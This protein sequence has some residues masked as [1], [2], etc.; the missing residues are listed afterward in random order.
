MSH[1]KNAEAF[2][3]LIGQCTGYAGGYQPGSSNLQVASMTALLAE[4]RESLDAVYSAKVL[5]DNATNNREVAFREM[6]LRCTRVFNAL[7][8]CGAHALT[9]ADARASMIK[10]DGGRPPKLIEPVGENAAVVPE[11]KRAASGADFV[12]VTQHFAQFVKTVAA[13]EKYVTH[14]AE[15]TVDQ[16]Q[17]LLDTLKGL[18]ELVLQATVQLV[19]ARQQRNEVLYLKDG[20]VRQTFSAAKAYIKAAYGFNSAQYKAI[21]KIPFTFYDL[22]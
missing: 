18:N 22:P 2:G 13:E 9:L 21:S 19:R 12:S 10:M 8:A 3:K 1:I 11:K 7:K 14:E 6:R 15:L 17:Q 4:A 16:L 5:F 20:N